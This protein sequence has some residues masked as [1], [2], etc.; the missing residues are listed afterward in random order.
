MVV[1]MVMLMVFY[2]GWEMYNCSVM[3]VYVVGVG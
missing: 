2:I 1:F 3:G